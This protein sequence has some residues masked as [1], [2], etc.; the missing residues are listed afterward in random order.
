MRG[1]LGNLKLPGYNTA[2]DIGGGTGTLLEYIHAE[3]PDMR[4]AN[5]DVPGLREKSIRQ[6]KA[7]GMDDVEFIG[8]NF[9]ENVPSGF[10]VYILKHI[11][12]DWN[13][14][15]CRII[16]RNI[17]RAIHQAG[18]L[19]I[20]DTIISNEDCV[21]R[22][23]KQDDIKMMALLDS[24]GRTQKQLMNLLK[25]NGFKLKKIKYN[26]EDISLLYCLPD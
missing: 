16:L 20:I 18:L 4:L 25:Q 10:D 11:L 14:E 5:F 1:L 15:K 19:L 6:L 3:N 9:F 13:D 24:E 17:R 12:H 7:A 21:G 8:G 2:I 22:L 26:I 23:T